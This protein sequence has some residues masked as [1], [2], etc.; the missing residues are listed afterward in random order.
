M[1]INVIMF[2]IGETLTET[3]GNRIEENFKELKK[4]QRVAFIASFVTLVLAV[5]K[6]AIGYLFDSKIL[7]ADAFH[8]GADLLAIFASWFGLWMASKKKSARFPYGLYKAET[9]V[10]FIIGALIAWAG[11]E[12]LKEGYHIISSLTLLI[13][14]NF[15][16]YRLL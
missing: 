8:S 10:S 15:R 5:M 4:G 13:L 11:I 7:I 1:S 2:Y 12:L 16:Y 9:L 3:M 14:R 6:G